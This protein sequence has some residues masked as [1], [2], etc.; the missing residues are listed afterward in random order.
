M[1]SPDIVSSEEFLSMP[2]SSQALYFHLGMHADDDGFI[3]PKPVMRLANIGD[4]D[5]RV[6]L[7]KRFLLT[8]ETGV[9]VI[10]HWLIHNMIR[11]DRYKPTRY[12]EEKE[13]LQIKENKAYTDSW[14]PNGN[15]MAAQ[16][17]LGEVS[18][19]EESATEAV[20]HVSFKKTPRG[21][22]NQRRI[23]SGR[24]PMEKKEMTEAQLK[25]LKVDKPMRYFHDKGVEM[26]YEYLEV[27]DE[28]A[29]KKF[30][31]MAR[32]FLTRYPENWKEVIEWWFTGKNEWCDFH[33]SGF[34]A[35]T[36]WMKFDNRAR[37]E[38]REISV[39]PMDI[40]GF[41]INNDEELMEAEKDGFVYAIDG[42]A[43]K[44]GLTPHG[45]E[46]KL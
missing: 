7:A 44:W 43:G 21:F 33:P 40:E 2:I 24:P 13:R 42:S 46:V 9:V 20:S 41:V 18:K 10:K 6:L 32:A 11:A 36:T 5:L 25:S 34:F 16:V 22:L 26:G 12:I 37:K 31:G 30:R 19:E 45:R 15:Q 38:G 4:D 27:E 1:F 29:N 23:E 17:R 3:N 39:Y 28:Q 14:Q 8:F 35:V